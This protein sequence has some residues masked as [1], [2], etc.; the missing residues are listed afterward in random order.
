MKRPIRL[1]RLPERAARIAGIPAGRAVVR[2]TIA[3]E[4][5]L[6]ADEAGAAGVPRDVTAR[7]ARAAEADRVVAAIAIDR[8]GRRAQVIGVIRQCGAATAAAVLAYRA[9]RG[10]TAVAVDA[11]PRD[12]L[13]SDAARSAESAL[14]GAHAAHA[15]TAG[16]AA[17]AVPQ[18]THVG[19]DRASGPARDAR[20]LAR[21]TARAGC[22]G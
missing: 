21:I 22:P 16:A 14:V 17:R 2:G 19:T 18:G 7:A 15:G 8:S 9:A 3:A 20:G 11:I 5:R 4:P 10:T 12:A 13:V 1:A 6:R